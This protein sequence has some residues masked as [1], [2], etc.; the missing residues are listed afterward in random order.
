MH[1]N[2]AEVAKVVRCFTVLPTLFSGNNAKSSAPF[3]CAFS[4]RAFFSLQHS[5]RHQASPSVSTC[6]FCESILFVRLEALKGNERRVVRIV[7]MDELTL[8]ETPLALGTVLLKWIHL[9]D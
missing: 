9:E 3:R 8:D 6:S 5:A 4:M 7:G 1:S 2:A